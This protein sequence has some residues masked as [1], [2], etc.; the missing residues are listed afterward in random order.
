M[1][2]DSESDP[3]RIDCVGNPTVSQATKEAADA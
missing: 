1:A 3:E 2:P